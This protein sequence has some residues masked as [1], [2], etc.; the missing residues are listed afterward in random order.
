MATNRRPARKAT[1]APNAEGIN[2]PE[3]CSLLRRSNMP[4]IAVPSPNTIKRTWRGSDVLKAHFAINRFGLRQTNKRIS[5]WAGIQRFLERYSVRLS[6]EYENNNNDLEI[7]DASLGN[8]DATEIYARAVFVLVRSIRTRFQ[9]TQPPAYDQTLTY[10]PYYESQ[11]AKEFLAYHL[12][13]FINNYIIKWP[14]LDIKRPDGEQNIKDWEQMLGGKIG[15]ACANFI[16]EHGWDIN[17]AGSPRGE[18][19]EEEFEEEDAS[20]VIS[21]HLNGL[22]QEMT[23]DTISHQLIEGLN[24]LT[25]AL[26]DLYKLPGDTEVTLSAVLRQT[27]RDGTEETVIKILDELWWVINSSQTPVFLLRTSS[28]EQ[29]TEQGPAAVN[30]QTAQ[31]KPTGHSILLLEPLVSE[32]E[33]EKAKDAEALFRLIRNNYNIGHHQLESMF[34]TVRQHTILRLRRIETVKEIFR[35]VE[36]GGPITELEGLTNELDDAQKED[37]RSML[38]LSHRYDFKAELMDI[39]APIK[40]RNLEELDRFTKVG[41]IYLEY[42]EAK[43]SFGE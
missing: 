15:I 39:F 8:L 42:L 34:E 38:Q 19:E 7:P 4:R 10:H 1:I 27:A 9:G 13:S 35:N 36:D 24:S 14:H 28:K 41:R 6:Q 20:K 23:L 30:R 2:P 11:L 22:K 16:R 37:A 25:D 21:F 31:E 12:L 5:R 26:R 43:Q 32:L 40:Q 3:G 29:R 17:V 18:P 33:E